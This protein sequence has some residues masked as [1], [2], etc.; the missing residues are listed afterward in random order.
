MQLLT[1]FS[2]FNPNAPGLKPRVKGVYLYLQWLL[3]ARRRWK[4]I[5]QLTLVN[6]SFSVVV[7]WTIV[8]TSFNHFW[9]GVLVSC[10][11]LINPSAA[12][13]FN[14]NFH[15]LEVVSR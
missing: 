4:Y 6:I 15:P 14:C 10:S 11:G 8:V 5:L 3:F 9:G 7:Y 2:G 12:E 13:L 1:I